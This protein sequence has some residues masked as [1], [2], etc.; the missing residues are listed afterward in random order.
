MIPALAF[1]LIGG[2]LYDQ[3]IEKVLDRQF[4][5]S[6]ISYLLL[7]T[8]TGEVVAQ[9]WQRPERPVPAG[10]LVKPFVALAASSNGKFPVL[11]CDPKNCWLRKGHGEMDIT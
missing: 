11:T 9:R 2:G 5:D 7:N 1:L 3:S 6:A 8:A 10:S 4:R